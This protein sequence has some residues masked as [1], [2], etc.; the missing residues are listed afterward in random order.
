MIKKYQPYIY[1]DPKSFLWRL[2]EPWSRRT[3]FGYDVI[4]SLLIYSNHD[5][6]RA[7]ALGRRLS[8]MAANTVFMSCVNF[9]L[10]LSPLPSSILMILLPFVYYSHPVCRLGTYFSYSI[11]KSTCLPV[12][13]NICRSFRAPS[14][15]FHREVLASQK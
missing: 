13:S 5:P 10:L 15:N 9:T 12:P 3:W 2:M 14:S 7:S 4:T 1:T 6:T 8:D 11:K